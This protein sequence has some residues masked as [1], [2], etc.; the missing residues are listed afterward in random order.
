MFLKEDMI[1]TLNS[2]KEINMSEEVYIGGLGAITAMGVGKTAQLSGLISGETALGPLTLF[3]TG[4]S[5]I[6]GEVKHSNQELAIMAGLAEGE[7]SRTTLLGLL[8]AKE[9]LEDSGADINGLRVGF[10]SATSVGGMDVSE[11]FYHSYNKD[12]HSGRLR[13]LIGHDC[14]AST[15]FI[16]GKLDINS[17]VTTINTACSSA[18]NAIMMGARMIKAGLLDAVIAG[19]TDSLCRF[20]INGFSSLGILDSEKCRPFDATRSGLNLGE[21][22]GYLFLHSAKVKTKRSYCTI[23]GYANANDA[24]HQTASSADGVGSYL[25][26]SS[27]LKM[28]G[29]NAQDIGYINVH[30]TGTPNNDASEGVAMNRLFSSFIPPFSSTKGFTGHTLGAAGGVESLFAILGLTEGY[31]WPNLLFSQSIVEV[32]GMVPVTKT[33]KVE[34]MI[35]VLTNSFGFGG[36]C[37]SIIYKKDKNGQL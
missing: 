27:A 37:S 18:N 4:H 20:T 15:Q 16:A 23:A 36:N 6:V 28:S 10:I 24:F 14:G 3:N 35:S 29:L 34:G 9:A 32:P 1:L 2:V 17:F 5:V 22:A 7:Y 30:G 31:H 21:G 8:A 13:Q 26:M 11:N 12:N 25:A 33:T 19:G